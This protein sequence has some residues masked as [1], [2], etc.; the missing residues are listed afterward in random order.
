MFHAAHMLAFSRKTSTPFTTFF[1]NPLYNVQ[2]ATAI[3]RI[4]CVTSIWATA[5]VLTVQIHK[6]LKTSCFHI[7]SDSISSGFYRVHRL[8]VCPPMTYSTCLYRTLMPDFN[9]CLCAPVPTLPI[10]THLSCHS[11]YHPS[12]WFPL[13]PHPAF[14]LLLLLLLVSLIYSRRCAVHTHSTSDTPPPATGLISR[15]GRLSSWSS[16][17]E[18]KR[19]GERDE[20]IGG[21][22]FLLSRPDYLFLTPLSASRCLS[23]SVFWCVCVFMCAEVGCLSISCVKVSRPW[24]L[25]HERDLGVFMEN[26]RR[27]D[28]IL[29]VQDTHRQQTTHATH[30]LA[31]SLMQTHHIHNPQSTNPHP[32]TPPL[33]RPN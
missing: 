16:D 31:R 27:P 9:P 14:P 19:E 1:D 26:K 6:I 28:A 25:L 21:V 17:V 15:H 10:S 18:K 11:S 12:R 8:S 30:S 2:I 7:E 20:T 13:F 4:L 3:P 23:R 22:L 33:A 24:R 29:Q 5:T 32:R